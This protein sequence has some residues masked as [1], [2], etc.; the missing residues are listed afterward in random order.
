M[1][2]PPTF[3]TVIGEGNIV[4]GRDV[5]ITNN[6]AAPQAAD[7]ASLLILLGKVKSDWLDGFLKQDR[8]SVV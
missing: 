7:R 2:E 4:A 6:Y 8:K 5:N 1:P 3:Q